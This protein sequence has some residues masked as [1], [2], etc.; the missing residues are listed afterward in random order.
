MFADLV[1]WEIS[2]STVE[3]KLHANWAFQ[4]AV[5]SKNSLNFAEKLH[6]EPT[7]TVNWPGIKSVRQRS[8]SVK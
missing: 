4:S 8:G 5:Q 1:C 7:V 2:L 6:L 3:Q